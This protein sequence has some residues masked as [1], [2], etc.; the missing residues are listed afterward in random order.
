MLIRSADYF[1][2]LVKRCTNLSRLDGIN[3]TSKH[4]LQQI[5]QCHNPDDLF[6]LIQHWDRSHSMIEHPLIHFKEDVTTVCNNRIA[7]ANI[8]DFGT[9]VHHD[10]RRS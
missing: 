4:Q 7:I 3:A 10:F 5:Q 1:N 6:V 9:Y 2:N 8:F